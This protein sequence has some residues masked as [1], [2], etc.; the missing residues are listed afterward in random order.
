MAAI[1]PQSF[2]LVA[3]EFPFVAIETT[4]ACEPGLVVATAR[5]RDPT[6]DFWAFDRALDRATETNVLTIAVVGPA[7]ELPGA[8][9]EL[10]TR[11]QRVLRRRNRASASEAFDAVLERHRA[12]HAL[13]LPLVRA[14]YDHALDTWQWLLRLAPDASLA[15]QLA[16]LLHDVERLRSE[17]ERRVEQHAGDYQQFKDQH[18]ARGAELAAALLREA[19][20]ADA[21]VRE[22]TRLIAAHERRSDDRELAL[23][24]DAD[25]LS[26]FAL[27]SA[28]FA[29]YY[30]PEHTQKKIA[31]SSNRLSARARAHL[32][33]MRLRP[34]VRAMLGRALA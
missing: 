4:N 26:F 34:D 11:C 28:G 21:L 5:W 20:L 16:A 19:G 24:N 13:S 18:A 2:D 15:L 33:H 29:D 1:A 32:A 12:L 6:F 30:G 17:P 7:A 22:T 3:R 14:D 27:N 31:Y 8:S 10:L 23:L 25:A 9:L